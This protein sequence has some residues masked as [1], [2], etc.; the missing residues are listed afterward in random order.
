LKKLKVNVKMHGEHNVK[1]KFQTPTAVFHTAKL[2]K[3]CH[4]VMPTETNAPYIL[5]D[6]VTPESA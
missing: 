5:P 1:L 4:I 2:P 3:H 6:N